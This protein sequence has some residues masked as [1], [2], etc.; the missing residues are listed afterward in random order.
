MTV[1]TTAT[2]T[3][4]PA[5]PAL[6]RV[7]IVTP[8][9]FSDLAVPSTTPIA[10]L[11][12][13]IVEHCGDDE[14]RERPMVL[15]RLGAAPLDRDA[16]LESAGVRDGHTL[17]LTPRTDPIPSMVFDDLIDG[18]AT[19]VAGRSDGWSKSATGTMFTWLAAA[20]L[21]FGVFVLAWSGP[22]PGTAVASACAAVMLMIIAALCAGAFEMTANARISAGFAVIYSGISGAAVPLTVTDPANDELPGVGGWMLTSDVV[23]A[24][25]MAVTVASLVGLVALGAS[26]EALS[27]IATLGVGGTTVGALVGWFGVDRI[28]AAAAITAV[29]TLCAPMYPS[30]AY[31]LA[32]IR[33]PD[34][35]TDPK[36]LADDLVEPLPGDGVRSR[37][38]NAHFILTGLF[39]GTSTVIGASLLFVAQAPGTSPIVLTVVTVS[40]L[41]LRARVLNGRRQRAALIGAAFLGLCSLGWRMLERFSLENRAIAVTVL[42]LCLTAVLLYA[43]ASMPGARLSPYWGRSADILE[44]LLAVVLLPVLF[45]VLGLYAIARGY[46]G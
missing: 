4:K 41:L 30:M 9:S 18:I 32:R 15:Q 23:L 20:V 45:S 39:I 7:T 25:S 5:P 40:V 10:D 26:V 8:T 38:T 16:T 24:G 2:A 42:V 13:A 35:P 17:H 46:A 3:A 19:T 43:A 11:V 29:F 34:L 44:S 14:L 37:A 36:D 6:C 31:R 27:S 12:P 1:T 28:D 22:I 21:A 33:P